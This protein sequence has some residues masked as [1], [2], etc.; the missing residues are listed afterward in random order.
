MKP[1]L[2][3]IRLLHYKQKVNKYPVVNL[4]DVE[5]TKPRFGFRRIRQPIIA[6]SKITNTLFPNFELAK[7]YIEQGKRIPNRFMNQTTPEIAKENFEKF[8]E[9]IALGEPHF[10]LG[11]N[12]V[13]FPQGR[14][15]LLRNNAKHTPYQAKFLVPKAMN[16]MDLRDYLWNIYGLRALNITVQ[17]QP[18]TWKRGPWDLGRYRSPQLKKMTVDMADPF[19]WPEVPKSLVD[20]LEDQMKN[21]EKFVEL[22]T[23]K[24]SDKDK[25]LE[26]NDGMYKQDKLPNTY[27]PKNKKKMGK[28]MVKIFNNEMNKKSQMEQ[29]NKY[30]N[31]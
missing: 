10:K 20:S 18:G 26:N 24:G 16:K 15:C 7:K 6:Q 21:G 27:I 25:P 23:A 22:N 3:L 14:I 29:L 19:I 2:N 11:N 31:L 12:K 8:Q 4:S 1:S 30:L 28:K 5:L 9:S 17:L 13:Y